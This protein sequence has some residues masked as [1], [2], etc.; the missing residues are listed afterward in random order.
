MAPIKVV[1]F[2]PKEAGDGIM[3]PYEITLITGSDYD[4][5]KFYL[6]RKD[7]PL[8]KKDNKEIRRVLIDRFGKS[9]KDDINIF[10][11]MLSNPIQKPVAK[12]NYP[13]LWKEYVKIAYKAE[14]PIEG[15]LYRNNKI[16]DMTWEVLTHSDT[17]D[18]ILNPGGFEEQKQVG[19]LVQAARITGKSVEELE[20]LGTSQLK[21]ICQ[22][23]KNIAFIG[24]HLQFYK[25]N[26]AASSILAI[27]AVAKVAH[28]CL[29]SNGFSVDLLLVCDIDQ[30]YS[31]MGLTLYDNVELDPQ[32][33]IE[34]T[35]IGKTLGSLVA[36]AADAVKDPVLNLMN[37]NSDTVNILNTL[38][39]V[40]LPFR[41]AAKLLSTKV[42]SDLLTKYN[43]EKLKGFT[44]FNTILNDSIQEIINNLNIKVSDVNLE[45]LTEEEVNN[46]ILKNDNKVDYKILLALKRVGLI[47]EAMSGLN[48]ATRFNSISSAVGP[49]IIDNL[50]IEHT[51]AKHAGEFPGI[52]VNG[53]DAG[54]TDVF[55]LH[56]I[57]EKFADS[58]D[59]ARKLFG[60]H[61]PTYSYQFGHILECLKGYTLL[62]SLFRDRKLFSQFNDFYQ[63]YLLVANSVVS[64]DA[65]VLKY[66]IEDFPK[67]FAKHKTTYAGNP[68]IDAIR[69]DVDSESGNPVLKINTT[70]LDAEAKSKLISGWLDLYKSGNEGKKLALDLF[71]Y[72]FYKGGIGFNPQ[73]FM[74]LLPIQ[75][76]MQLKGYKETFEQL[77]TISVSHFLDCF[78]RNNWHND[79]VVPYRKFEKPLSLHDGGFTDFYEADALKLQNVLAFKTE[80]NGKE[81]FFIQTYFSLS[82]L[83][84]IYK[85]ATPLGNGGEFVEIPNIPT[86]DGKEQ[87]IT[88]TNRE[89]NSLI[90]ELEYEEVPVDTSTMTEQQAREMADDIF[91][92][93]STTDAIT[94]KKQ[95]I[96]KKLKEKGVE[97][98][99]AKAEDTAKK[100]C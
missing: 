97:V 4:I 33:D 36:S 79:K 87:P 34:G 74:T 26:A 49:L 70:G 7:I 51:L 47:N 38:I 71:Q 9:K 21:K 76:K 46:A 78:I 63:S 68:F 98:D 37:I 61:M 31:I 28:A 12:A 6:M 67:E 66:Y 65:S 48:F 62:D 100:T 41:K 25:Q 35:F 5:D 64:G 96:V 59:V 19:Y 18:K 44:T 40:G 91:G 13:D 53:H 10:L 84:A 45:D 52:F 3:L 94:Q 60:N 8:H 17:A 83:I 80:I 89:Y 15:R 43:T 90:E 58:V 27:F 57:L 92:K 32:K 86:M 16:I 23:D 11:D 99:E 22:T 24:T 55:N 82:N 39:R 75:V 93:T 29:E 73:T 20:N 1:G 72:C 77:P 14:P 2:M 88:I 85:M 95:L 69:F 42:V 81:L 54:F 50:K 30:P 56:P